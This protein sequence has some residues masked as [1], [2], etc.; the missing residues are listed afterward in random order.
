M[1]NDAHTMTAS[2]G[3]SAATADAHTQ[4]PCGGGK[5]YELCCAPLHDGKKQPKDALELMRAR[6]SAYVRKRTEYLLSTWHASTRPPTL[7]LSDRPGLRTHWL[8]LQIISHRI[9]DTSRQEVSFIARV[10][11]GGGPAQ[12]MVER[13]RFLLDEGVWYYVDGEIGPK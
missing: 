12:R 11:V 7:D 1:F 2:S 3:Q 10:K 4:C 8:G 9:L 5:S 13:S 6:Y